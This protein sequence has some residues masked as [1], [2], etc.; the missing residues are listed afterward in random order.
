MK[1]LTT[2]TAVLSWIDEM[3]AITKP[4]N[5]VWIDGSEDQLNMLRKQ[6]VD[7]GILI[8]LNQA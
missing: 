1:A 3:A 8:E 4:D 5:I 7:E 6:A 2:N